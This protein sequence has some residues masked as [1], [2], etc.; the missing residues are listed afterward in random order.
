[1][2]RTLCYR[3]EY[4]RIC[5]MHITQRHYKDS[6][7]H[8]SGMFITVTTCNSVLFATNKNY[9]NWYIGFPILIYIMVKSRSLA[10]LTFGEQVSFLLIL[11]LLYLSITCVT[12]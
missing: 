11:T 12:K 7:P 1:M 5:K 2:E 9:I 10:I 6:T 3:D 8:H 4:K